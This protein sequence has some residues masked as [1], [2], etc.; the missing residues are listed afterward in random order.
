ML[1]PSGRALSLDAWLR[2]RFTVEF[3][4]SGLGRWLPRLVRRPCVDESP[5]LVAPWPVRVMQIQLC[6]VYLTTGLVKLAG[7]GFSPEAWP[8]GSWRPTA[9]PGGSWWDGTSIHYVFNY[10]TKS[11]WSSAQ[12][13]APFWVTM[14]MT[15]AVVWWEVLFTPLVLWR[16]TRRLAVWFGVLFHLGIWVTMEIGWF[17]PYVLSFY[18]VWLPSRFWARFDREQA[19]AP[20]GGLAG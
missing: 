13:T 8:E 1:A 19:A 18:A 9:P 14:V 12:L 4:S 6:L 11:R 15:Y 10:P 7:E 20:P 17:S 5:A 2:R 16:R 3:G